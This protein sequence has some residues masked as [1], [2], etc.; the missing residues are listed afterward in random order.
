MSFGLELR[1]CC[2]SASRQEVLETA[3]L[4]ALSFCAE[5]WDGCLRATVV[6]RHYYHKY[7]YHKYYYHKYYYH[8]YY[9]HKYYYHIYHDYHSGSKEIVVLHCGCLLYTS[10]SPRDYAASRMPSSA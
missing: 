10:P 4:H 8:K 6:H 5:Q 1:L 2:V 3:R 7:Y 9:Y